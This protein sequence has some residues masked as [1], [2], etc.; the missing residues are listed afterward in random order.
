VRDS[1]STYLISLVGLAHNDAQFIDEAFNSQ[2]EAFHDEYPGGA[3]W[4]KQALCFEYR[5]R[6]GPSRVLLELKD[7]NRLHFIS[8]KAN[9][10]RRGELPHRRPGVDRG[11]S[12]PRSGC[13]NVQAGSVDT[14]PH[15]RYEADMNKVMPFLLALALISTTGCSELIDARRDY[16][17]WRNSLDLPRQTTPMQQQVQMQQ[18]GQP[19]YRA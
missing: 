9:S 11:Q 15:T 17:Q 5:D 18:Y 2:K 14:E 6:V 7:G 3:T 13:Q 8:V 16:L 19:V 12:G 10:L 1:V 4:N